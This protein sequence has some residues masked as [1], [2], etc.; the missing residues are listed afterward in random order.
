MSDSKLELREKAI[1][2][3]IAHISEECAQALIDSRNLCKLRRVFAI[4]MLLGT[5][6]LVYIGALV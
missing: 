3:E 5:L 1:F 4:W 6:K 2:M